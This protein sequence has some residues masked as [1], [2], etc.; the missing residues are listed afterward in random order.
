MKSHKT[1]LNVDEDTLAELRDSQA[2]CEEYLNGW[3]RAMADYENLKKDAEKKTGELMEYAAAGI[4]S[5]L[6]PINNHFKL[7]I[8]HIPA[9]EQE[10]DWVRGVMHIKKEFENFLKKYE[11]NEIATVGEKFNPEL[12]E[13]VGDEESEQPEE[14]IIAEVQPGYLIKDKVFLPAKV[15]VSKA[16]PSHQ[17]ANEASAGE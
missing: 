16:K 2:K 11:I 12:H 10:K 14:S 3:K 6:M 17:N 5:D 8:K 1:D 13:A 9:A 15:I 4:I 7:A